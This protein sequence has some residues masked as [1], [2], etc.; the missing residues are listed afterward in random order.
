MRALGLF[1]DL[2]R[3]LVVVVQTLRGFLK[4]GGDSDYFVDL[5]DDLTNATMHRIKKHLSVLSEQR[6]T[7]LSL[8]S[9]CTQAAEIVSSWHT[10][11][12]LDIDLG[13]RSA[14]I[15]A[16]RPVAVALKTPSS[17]DKVMS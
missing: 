15:G 4:P 3:R 11:V 14:F 12:L 2:S 8:K 1:R 6:E 13:D 9:G 16:G 5:T 10:A 17:V 7:L